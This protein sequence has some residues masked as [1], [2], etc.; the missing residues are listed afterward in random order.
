MKGNNLGKVKTL[1]VS[2]VGIFGFC[3]LKFILFE[4]C[5]ELIALNTSLFF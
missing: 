4:A 2:I 3:M 5:I 1:T